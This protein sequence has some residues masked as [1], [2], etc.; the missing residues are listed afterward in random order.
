MTDWL[1]G[2]RNRT[3]LVL[4]LVLLAAAPAI[5]LAARLDGL[6][7]LASYAPSL[8]I[9]TALALLIKVATFWRAGLYLRYWRYAS[10][11]ELAQIVLAVLVASAVVMLTYY[12]FLAPT[13]VL[14]PSLPRSVGPIDALLSLAFVGGTRFAVRWAESYHH[15]LPRGKELRRVLVIGAG[16]AGRMI[17]REMQANPHLGMEPIGFVDDDPLKQRLQIQRIPVLGDSQSIV[18]VAATYHV[19]EAIIAMP[20]APGKTIRELTRLCQDAKLPV[21][22]VP[23]MFEMLDGRVTVSR[24]RSVE[25][26][27]LLRRE[28][29]PVDLS[30]VARLIHGQRVLVSGAGGSIGRELCRQ[31]VR[32][33]P[34]D[35]ILLGHG[36]NSIFEILNELQDGGASYLAA[37]RLHPV[38]ADIRDAD[39]LCP[40]STASSPRWCCMPPRTSTSR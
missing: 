5:A 13:S 33:A 34:A 18:E 15:R 31:I 6:E 9:F 22:T 29:V 20:T 40:S 28:P 2:L 35:L 19:T 23:G 14:A 26:T 11:D 39:R 30:N 12:G 1:V 38:I 27:D 24:I 21:K 37:T 25:I 8:T 4:D 10:V 17:V 7:P 16:D 36:E 32:G 3:F